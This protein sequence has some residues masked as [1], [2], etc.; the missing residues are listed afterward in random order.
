MLHCYYAIAGIKVNCMYGLD[1]VWLMRCD[2]CRQ[3]GEAFIFRLRVV[4]N[5]FLLILVFW[6]IYVAS[7]DW[8]VY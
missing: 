7:L 6:G 2:D 8:V 1:I 5:T 4:Y 3:A